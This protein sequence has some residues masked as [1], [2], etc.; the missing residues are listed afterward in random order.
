MMQPASLALLLILG[1]TETRAPSGQDLLTL[2][3]DYNGGDSIDASTLPCI[4]Y[5]A[6]LMD[7]ISNYETML[8]MT[9]AFDNLQ[10]LGLLA[11]VGA[12]SKETLERLQGSD[13][14]ASIAA[15]LAKTQAEALA[16]GAVRSKVVLDPVALRSMLKREICIPAGY[17][18]PGRLLS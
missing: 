7:A 15:S 10:H 1:P 4:S 13:A 11:R 2:C 18:A 16:Q 12:L 17:P 6:G 5:V 9:G 3:R 8:E 14:T